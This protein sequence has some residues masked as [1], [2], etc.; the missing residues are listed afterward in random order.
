ME[1]AKDEDRKR[2]RHKTDSYTG[3]FDE[4]AIYSTETL[5]SAEDISECGKN[6]NKVTARFLLFFSTSS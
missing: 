3:Q 5:D 4:T 6:K 1:S 2:K